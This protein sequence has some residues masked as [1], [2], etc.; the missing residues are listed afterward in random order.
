MNL[1][2][3][4]IMSYMHEVIVKFR[5]LEDRKVFG[6]INK[7]FEGDTD[8]TEYV[9]NPTAIKNALMKQIPKKPLNKTL[10]NDDYAWEWTCPLCR[11]VNVSP[12]YK[13]CPDCG[14]ALDWEVENE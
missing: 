11:V 14:Q 6:E 3:N 8:V 1:E 2:D 7:Y 10:A 4:F 12:E 9:L 5:E 13:H